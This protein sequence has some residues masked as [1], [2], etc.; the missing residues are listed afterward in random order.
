MSKRGTLLAAIAFAALGT[1]SANAAD[2]GG[3]KGGSMKDSGYMPAIQ[4][5]QAASA[6]ICAATSRWANQSL[7]AIY[8][9][10]AY[11]LSMPSIENTRS[12]GLGVGRYFSSNVRGD[13]T[14]DWRS[15]AGVRGTVV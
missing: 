9:P 5:P 3:M 2:L 6:C 12:W 10:P 7:G 11:T 14:F 1:A 4:Q 15:E 8:E 13:L